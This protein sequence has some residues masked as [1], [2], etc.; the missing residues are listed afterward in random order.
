VLKNWRH[1]LLTQHLV[2][3]TA[4]MDFENKFHQIHKKPRSENEARR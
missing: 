1:Q 4:I 2:A 3:S